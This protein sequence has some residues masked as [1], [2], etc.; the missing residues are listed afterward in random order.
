MQLLLWIDAGWV[1]FVALCVLLPMAW[2]HCR[3]RANARAA[4]ENFALA[5]ARLAEMERGDARRDWEV[6]TS[7]RRFFFWGAFGAAMSNIFI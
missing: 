4:A 7:L 3:R 6:R 2:S 1:S 5:R